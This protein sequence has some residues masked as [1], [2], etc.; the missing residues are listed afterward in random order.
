MLRVGIEQEFVFADRS[1]HYLDADNSDYGLFSRIVDAFPAY[2]EDAAYLECKSLET[3]PKRCYVEGFERHDRDGRT[4]DTQPKGLEIR[5]LPHT[6]VEDMVA[7][8]RQSWRLLMDEA[9][10]HGLSPLLTSRHPFKTELEVHRRLDPVERRV[11]SEKQL[12]LAV[13]AMFT[14]GLHVSV[15]FDHLG[16]REM[17]QL[18]EK[19]NYYAPVLIPWSFSSPF[20][21]G[22]LFAGLCARNYMR[23]DSRSLAD[24]RLRC[25]VTVL[26]FRGFDT[27]GDA[28]LLEAVVR[29]FCGVLLDDVLPGHSPFQDVERLKRSCLVGFADDALRAEGVEMLAAARAVMGEARGSFGL[30]ESLLVGNDSY[31]ARMKERFRA[32]GSI[33]ESIS[34]QYDY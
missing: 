12:Q 28:S 1:R 27:C 16:S 13:R 34:G 30:L 10:R 26:E 31:A 18:V 7:E 24:L 20:Y 23:A 15:S 8:F 33:M 17:Q 25:G 6:T 21:G 19:L 32:T 14:H 3:Y 4:L 29:L 11:R 9:S 22:D 2:P 5:T